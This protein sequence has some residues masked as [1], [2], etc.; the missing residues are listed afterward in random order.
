MNRCRAYVVRRL[1]YGVNVASARNK[2]RTNSGNENFLSW[3]C[4]VRERLTLA[5]AISPFL[6]A[7]VLNVDAVLTKY[8]PRSRTQSH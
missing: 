3:V 2:F 8:A 5:N 4:R 1:S 7:V 6:N